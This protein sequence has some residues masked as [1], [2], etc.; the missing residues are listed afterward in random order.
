MEADTIDH[1]PGPLSSI[2]MRNTVLITAALGMFSGCGLQET[3]PTINQAVNE[4]QS[5]QFEKALN[6]LGTDK[7]LSQSNPSIYYNRGVA[8]YKLN[9]LDKALDSFKTADAM[10]KDYRIKE[11]MAAIYLAKGMHHETLDA[12]IEADRLSPDNPR[13]LTALGMLEEKK[14][15]HAIA[16]R[17]LSGALKIDPDYA[18]AIYNAAVIHQE[19]GNKEKSRELFADY[20]RLEPKHPKAADAQDAVNEL[21]L[22]LEPPEMA[23]D[24]DTDI[25]TNTIARV[26]MA[27]PV[28]S[29]QTEAVDIPE[30]QPDIPEVVDVANQGENR[31][32]A[33]PDPEPEDPDLPIVTI[34]T[35]VRTSIRNQNYDRALVGIQRILADH[36][37]HP[38]TLWEMVRVRQ[39]F[40][41]ENKLI[42]AYQD[43][44]L[45]APDD[46]RAMDAKRAL[47][48]LGAPEKSIE[49]ASSTPSEIVD[50]PDP[51][52]IATPD[53]PD[54]QEVAET[55][56]SAGR[57]TDGRVVE[58]PVNPDDQSQTRDGTN[59]RLQGRKAYNPHA[60]WAYTEAT[61]AYTQGD[62][63]KALKYY[64]ESVDTDPTLAN[65]WYNMGLVQKKMAD[66]PAAAKSLSEALKQDPSMHRARYMLAVVY[67]FQGK[68]AKARDELKTLIIKQ[69]DFHMAYYVL[70]IVY[71]ELDKP[72]EALASFEQLVE[73]DDTNPE[74]HYMAG[75]MLEETKGP[76]ETIRGHY[77]RYLQ[78][79]P[80]GHGSEHAKSWLDSNS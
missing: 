66:Y 49:D 23:L 79:A 80:D 72:E 5:G 36:P 52:T 74:A 14:N 78:L 1:T 17:R 45:A 47:D 57:N 42:K 60:V 8:F 59:N 77:S 11:F 19:L 26:E 25:D 35:D 27:L 76:A 28:A 51:T 69:P 54:E 70:G 32:V 71:R 20:L 31:A 12:L 29:N 63:A 38:D 62:F 46:L 34:L 58:K 33:L 21:T 24:T 75:V 44:L 18:P 3:G 67:R 22:A 15:N 64:K 41:D 6:R 53:S 61:T 48:E 2:L 56:G 30:I 40:A 50:E 13:I 65:A 9:E 10:R 68:P 7:M 43:F 16:L 73:R 37:D 55:D 39:A 4:I